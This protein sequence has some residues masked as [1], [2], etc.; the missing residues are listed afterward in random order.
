MSTI[1]DVLGRKGGTVL[2]VEGSMSV[3]DAIK[4]MSEANIG[5]LVIQDNEQPVGIFTE[6]DYM[7]KIALKGRSSS[8]T[9]VADVMSSPLI[10]VDIGES[11][12]IAMETMTQCSCRHLVV[13]DKESMAGII[14]L[15]DTVKHML[16][17]KEAE[18]EQLSSYIAGSY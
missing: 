3:F 17:D 13:M 7:K 6:R 2:T 5:A 11:V 10:T 4:T 15:G 12:Q 16:L 14:S 9:A 8:T 18:I 1:H